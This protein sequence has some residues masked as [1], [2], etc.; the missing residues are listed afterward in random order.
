M[1]AAGVTSTLVLALGLAGCVPDYVKDNDSPVL[2]L[3]AAINGGQVLQS[4]VGTI[5]S[6]T[7]SVT[8]AVR[9]KNPLNSN[10]PQVAEAVIVEQ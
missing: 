10:L 1:R 9:P 7:V 8:L 2:F 6:D 4:D 3:I 5:S